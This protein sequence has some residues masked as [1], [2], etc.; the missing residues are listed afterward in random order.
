ME[1]PA[2]RL[3]NV[4]GAGTGTSIGS[5]HLIDRVLPLFLVV[6]D[7]MELFDQSST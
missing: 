2:V 4:I 5:T 6:T 3:A 1:H 7:E